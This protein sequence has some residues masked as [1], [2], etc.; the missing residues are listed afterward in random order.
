MKHRIRI[1]VVL[2]LLALLAVGWVLFAPT[3]AGYLIVAKPLENPDAILVLSGSSVYSERTMHAAGLFAAGIAPRIVLTDDGLRGPW[4]RRE[5]TNPKFVEMARSSLVAQG[6]PDDRI[7][8]LEPTVDGTIEEAW[9]VVKNARELGLKRIV[10]VTS[11]YHSRRALRTFERVASLEN[12]G[13]E[14][15]IDPVPTG[16]QTPEPEIW[17]HKGRG[18]QMV[19]GEFLKSLYYWLSY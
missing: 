8:V 9:L 10:I 7:T 2:I 4:S 18:W 1:I 13:I 12:A 16:I 3:L 15:G 19:G 5:Q 17:W 6:V 14:F 11:A